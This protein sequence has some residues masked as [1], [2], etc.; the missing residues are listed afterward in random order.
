MCV[1][2]HFTCTSLTI[3][4]AHPVETQA[5]S[6][7]IVLDQTV[8]NLTA[9]LDKNPDKVKYLSNVSPPN[10]GLLTY[11]TRP[12]VHFWINFGFKSAVSGY[13]K[14]SNTIEQLEVLD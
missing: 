4:P 13:K 2:S 8:L 7:F 5:K 12:S 14:V 3:Q 9:A 10:Q 1:T 11:I 6:G